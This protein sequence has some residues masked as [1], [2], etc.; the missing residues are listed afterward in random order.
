MDTVEIKKIPDNLNLIDSKYNLNRMILK[1]D[2]SV[3]AI[4]PLPLSPGDSSNP[5]RVANVTV[6]TSCLQNPQIKLEFSINITAPSEDIFINLTFQ[7]FKLCNNIFQKI[8]VGPKFYYKKH[9]ELQGSDIFN[10]FVYDD[11]LRSRCCT[12]IIEAT[13]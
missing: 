7:V 13:A 5:I 12:Y 2:N 8:P 1:W 6:D 3:S 4:I 9:F 10:F 11:L